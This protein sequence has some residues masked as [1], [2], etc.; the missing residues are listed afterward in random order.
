MN[1]LYRLCYIEMTSR[2]DLEKAL[3]WGTRPKIATTIDESASK[4][5]LRTCT[6]VYLKEELLLFF[7]KKVFDRRL[8]CSESKLRETPKTK[9]RQQLP[10][11]LRCRVKASHK[12]RSGR[13]RWRHDFS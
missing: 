9:P 10:H 12:G 2:F 7:S 13:G 11:R 5:Y 8:N 3:V 4:E 1:D 6:R